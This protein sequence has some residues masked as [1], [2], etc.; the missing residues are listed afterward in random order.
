VLQSMRSAAKYIWIFIVVVFVGV[1]L[2]TETSG[3]LGRARIT[4]GTAVAKVNGDE[5]SYTTWVQAAQQ[6]IQ[7]EQQGRGRSLTLDEE[8]QIRNEVF[9]QLVQSILLDQEY[10]RRGIRVTDEEIVQAAQFSPP[11]Q[12]MQ[13]PEL[14]TDGR[15]D[16]EKYQRFLKSA[17]ARQQGLYFQLENYYRSEIPRAK[18]YEQVASE[19]FVTDD[20]MWRTFRDQHD[21]AK[22]SFVSFDPG[23]VPDSG[24]T[25]SDAE[26][27]AYFDSHKKELE[28][29]GRAVVTILSIP[30]VITAADSAAVRARARALR[31]EIL[32][33]AKFEDVAKR[34]SSDTL[35]GAQGGSLGRGPKG[36]FVEAFE[37]AAFALAPGQISEPVETQFGVHLIKVDEKKADTIAVRHILL[38]FQ[39]SDSSASRTDKEADQLSKIAASQDTPQP[40]DSAAKLLKLTPA[41]GVAIEGEGLTVAGQSVPSVSAWAFSGVKPGS[42]SD[43]FDSD[44]GYVLARL[45][46]VTA[47]GV[48]TLAQAHDQIKRTLMTEKK[49]DRLVTQAKEFATAAASS[50]MDAAAQSKNVKVNASDAFTRIG[51][52]PGMGRVNEAIG[53]AFSLP[54]G[55]VSN[56]IRTQ[57]GVVVLRVD[58]RVDSDRTAWEAQKAAQRQQLMQSLRQQRIQAFLQ[59]LRAD[60]KIDD[61][62]KSLAQAARQTTS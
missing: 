13:S 52:V 55:V 41:T 36:R 20:E 19:A 10:K 38:R 40:F 15:F 4:T 58:R 47:G 50:S 28:Q 2:F 48:P 45:D 9:N 51:F 5:I 32:K 6:R 23:S 3:L 59:Q 27:S 14:Q 42:T 18:L 34:E 39:Q 61:R 25:V 29:P 60:A 49:L 53:A 30:R 22:V 12:F 33:G 26:I 17:A 46:S 35:S 8:E 62:R 54:I 43:L 31:D 37:K 7:Q 24:I 1:F 44:N 11:P 16:L 57:D 21:S 56:P